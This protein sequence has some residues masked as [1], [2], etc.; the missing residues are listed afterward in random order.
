MS[1]KEKEEDDDVGGTDKSRVR[2]RHHHRRHRRRARHEHDDNEDPAVAEREKVEDKAFMEAMDTKLDKLA[3]IDDDDDDELA[4]EVDATQAETLEK[5]GFWFRKK[6]GMMGKLGTS[7][8]G[9][10][11]FKKYMDEETVELLE[12][13]KRIVTKHKGAARSKELHKYIMRLA[14]KTILLYDNETIT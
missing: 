5:Q 13:S 4:D 8:L 9:N 14:V 2:H 7:R 10:A 12:T 1:A 3:I 11:L 6:K